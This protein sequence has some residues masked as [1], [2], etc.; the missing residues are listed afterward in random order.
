M[1]ERS[2]TTLKMLYRRV[3]L[4]QRV[5]SLVKDIIFLSLAPLI[6]HTDSYRV[7]RAFRARRGRDLSGS[8]KPIIGS[9]SV[10]QYLADLFRNAIARD[11]TDY[12]PLTRSGIPA[13]HIS[14]KLVAFYLPQYHP[15]PENDEW[16]GKGF[17][18][19]AN[20]S[21]A[22]PQF[23]GHYQP[24]LPGELGFYDLRLPETI[25]RQV[26]LARFYGIHGFCFYY[27][28]FAGRRLLDGPLDQYVR[29]DIDFPFC[30]CWANEN[31]TR[32][33][34][35]NDEDVL[36]AQD[37]STDNDFAFIRSVEPLLRD[38]RYIRIDG[39][40]LLVVYRPSIIPRV[41][42]TLERWRHYCRESGLGELFL[43]MVQFDVED[44]ITWGFDAAIEF[45]P[46]KLARGLVP[47]NESLSII[48]ADYTGCV[49]DYQK[50]VERARALPQPGYPL[51]RGVFPSWDNEARQPGWGYTFAFSTPNRYRDWLRMAIEYAKRW[52]V[53]G[54]RMVFINA[55]NEWSEG[56]YLEPD[57]RYGYAYL[58]ATRDALTADAE[59]LAARGIVVVS[60][61][62]HPHGAQY[63]AL[64]MVRTLTRTFSSMVEVV[65]LEGGVLESEFS[66]HAT[67]HRL[68]G[69][70]PTGEAGFA[71]AR[72]L[73]ARGIRLGIVNTT[74][75]GPFAAA[76]KAAG[77]R[78]ISLIHELPG[79][80]EQHRLHA[81]A[82][83][84][85]EHA[86]R[87]VFPAATVRAAFEGY[88]ALEDDRVLLRAQGVYKRNRFAAPARRKEARRA[89]R[90][91]LGIARD[92]RIVLSVGYADR[93]KGVDLFVAVAA[94]VIRE[95]PL[96]YF[97]W[98][99]HFDM[100][101]ETEIKSAA[102]ASGFGERILFLDHDPETDLYYAGADV[103]AL[104]SREDPF[105]TVALLALH[106]G[107]PVVAFDGTGG[108]V[109][110]LKDGCG[111]V[112]PAF[113]TD[114]FALQVRTLLQDDQAA[115]ACGDRGRA[116]VR[117]DHSFR[118]YVFDLLSQGGLAPPRV[119][120]VIPNYNYARYLPE[121]LATICR[122]SIPIY[123]IIVLDDASTDD[124]VQTIERVEAELDI[125]VRVVRNEANSGSVFRQW[126]R[127]VRLA[128]GDYVWIAE[129]DDLADHDFLRMVA[130]A[131][132]DPKV[133][134]SYSQ[135]KQIDAAGNVLADDYLEYT[136]DVNPLHWKSPYTIDGAEEVARFLAI[137][138]T[139]PNVSAVVFRRE[140]IAA[141]FDEA[142]PD[143]V[144]YNIAGDWLAYVKILGFGRVAFRPESLNLHRR[145]ARGVTI[146]SH[147]LPHLL[148]VLR[149]QK[150]VREHFRLDE[151]T[152]DGA[153]RYA[154]KLYEYFGLATAERPRIEMHEAAAPLL[155]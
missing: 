108:F 149:M 75:A 134:L 124:S 29:S 89:L 31:W 53:A 152:R 84:V 46:H 3:P 6:R 94:R 10:Q 100:S 70:A 114:A 128:R 153:R 82:R 1:V 68:D 19:W 137:K 85:A 63:L 122:Q 62:A 92:A 47:I 98:L 113:D 15:I 66:R 27:Y 97:L 87:I 49:I 101:W 104:T 64:H 154:Q 26:E 33:W 126:A 17:T 106:V 22:L 35:G 30:I 73:A 146:G 150:Y 119:S 78:T 138:N 93:R 105:P 136:F 143:I 91:R 20:V 145:H 141:A 9:S 69:V 140:A 38:S 57:R 11:D 41:A 79:V 95:D 110:L 102:R 61:D 48:N 127:G 111:R 116:V 58:Q 25:Q 21:K 120:A 142:M 40:P 39:R 12:V 71:L 151:A 123:E 55:W 59:A 45:P 139:I 56:A 86:D 43:V 155:Q 28:W 76:L 14:T 121:R 54:E 5:K 51:F 109:P 112:A 37:H 13:N 67:V 16:W 32:R 88:A 52:P 18:E 144:S 7:W 107:I 65:L 80:I 77:I 99:G 74:V 148:E 133:V 103:Y 131:F 36:I 115:Q 8:R 135:S 2:R 96:A 4:P 129:S 42:Q 147:Q 117:R 118:A 125:D 60:H 81:H 50:V 90:R 72:T 44:P 23:V 132:A 83:A 34:D 24:R 130:A